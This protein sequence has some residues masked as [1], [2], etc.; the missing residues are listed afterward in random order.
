[1]TTSNYFNFRAPWDGESSAAAGERDDGVA[2]AVDG[3]LR[4]AGGVRAQSLEDARVHGQRR[5]GLLQGVKLFKNTGS[6]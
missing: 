1:M 2:V 4:V 5:R 3:P 6:G